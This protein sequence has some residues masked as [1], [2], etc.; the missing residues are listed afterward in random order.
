M[1]NK[2]ID[3]NRYPPRIRGDVI[4]TNDN[5]DK[6]NK[7]CKRCGGTGNELLSM[8]R[9]CAACEGTGVHNEEWDYNKED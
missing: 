3:P 5:I 4:R 6:G 9:K 7:L 2:K 8:Y 1:A